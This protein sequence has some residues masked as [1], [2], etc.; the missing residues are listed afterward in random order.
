M[1]QARVGINFNLTT[2]TTVQTPHH[3]TPLSTDLAYFDLL[4]IGSWSNAD[5][6]AS[7]SFSANF[8][9]L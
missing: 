6:N 7:L 3:N 1:G 9:L 2:T 5:P 8:R 4:C